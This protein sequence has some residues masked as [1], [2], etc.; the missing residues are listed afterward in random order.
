V[1]GCQP[2]DQAAQRKYR[3]FEELPVPVKTLVRG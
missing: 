3:W 1:Q 2:P